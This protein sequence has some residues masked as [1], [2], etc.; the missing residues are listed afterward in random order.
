MNK[1]YSLFVLNMFDR[2]V[3]FKSKNILVVINV[4]SQVIFHHTIDITIMKILVQFYKFQAEFLVFSY[5]QIS[6]K[7]YKS[8]FNEFC[9]ANALHSTHRSRF[10]ASGTTL[11]I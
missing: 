4:I 6:S 10:V 7:M 11:S 8:Y 9:N 3:C 5:L 1:D 2:E